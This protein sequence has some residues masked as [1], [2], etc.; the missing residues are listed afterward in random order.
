MSLHKE[1][2]HQTGHISDFYLDTAWWDPC[3]ASDIV[4]E[5]NGSFQNLLHKEKIHWTPETE[6]LQRIFW[7]KSQLWGQLLGS[8]LAAWS[9][10][11]EVL[12]LTSDAAWRFAAVP[13]PRKQ[14]RQETGPRAKQLTSLRADTS[15]GPARGN[16]ENWPHISNLSCP[17]L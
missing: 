8:F 1:V 5:Y 14:K 13:E 6:A 12:S 11:W 7:V 2:P 17:L 9:L 16:P 4:T 10:G 15:R 3:F